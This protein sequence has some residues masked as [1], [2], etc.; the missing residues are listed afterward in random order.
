M[1][2][3]YKGIVAFLCRWSQFACIHVFYFYYLLFF[4][5]DVEIYDSGEAAY[6]STAQVI[7]NVI[8][9]PSGP[10]FERDPYVLDI[11]EAANMGDILQ[12]QAFDLDLV[13]S[14]D[15]LGFISELKPV[16]VHLWGIWGLLGSFSL[17]IM[18]IQIRHFF[19]II[20]DIFLFL[21][22]NVLWVLIVLIRSA[23]MR[24]F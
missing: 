3:I 22:E 6:I 1:E 24:C 4:Q 19:F 11:H 2:F 18:S 5:F 9:N 21:H 16:K 23:S 7:I 12:T 13:S 10:Q 8:K 17:H 20:S 14:L 15:Y